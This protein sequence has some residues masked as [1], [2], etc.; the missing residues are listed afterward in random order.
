MLI[1]QT[2]ELAKTHKVK[3]GTKYDKELGTKLDQRVRQ[4]GGPN[5]AQ[6]QKTAKGKGQGD[7]KKYESD[8]QRHHKIGG[9]YCD[10]SDSSDRRPRC[11]I[12][13]RKGKFSDNGDESNKKHDRRRLQYGKKFD[14]DSSDGNDWQRR[15]IKKKRNFRK[16][17]NK[18]KALKRLKYRKI[19]G[20][21]SSDASDWQRH[22]KVVKRNRKTDDSSDSKSKASKRKYN[23][24][25]RKKNT[26]KNGIPKKLEG[27]T[28]RKSKEVKGNEEVKRNEPKKYDNNDEDQRKEKEQLGSRNGKNDSQNEKGGKQL[29]NKPGNKLG[30]NKVMQKVEQLINVGVKEKQRCAKGDNSKRC[31]RQNKIPRK[32]YL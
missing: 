29:L 5:L 24:Q 20:D 11:R 18:R 25:N 19:F 21:D 17:S 31:R 26:N 6:A 30:E 28:S 13:N 8:R 4:G 1:A 22:F 23:N 7:F 12:G 14:S 15:Y 2:I 3:R 9:R 10:S 27:R 32:R 16:K